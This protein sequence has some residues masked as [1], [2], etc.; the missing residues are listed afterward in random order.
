[1]S[2][3]EKNIEIGTRSGNMPGFAA[4]P[5]E[6]G[7]VPAVIFYM[8]AP[9]FR[10]ELKTMARRIAKAGYFCVVPDM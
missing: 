10:E 8:D 3:W 9:G 4:A 5:A 1:M 7:A 6:G 2:L